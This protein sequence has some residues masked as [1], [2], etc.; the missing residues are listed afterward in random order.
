MDGGISTLIKTLAFPRTEAV[1]I[2]Q[3]FQNVETSEKKAL[4]R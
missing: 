1:Q 3:K 4:V 2:A